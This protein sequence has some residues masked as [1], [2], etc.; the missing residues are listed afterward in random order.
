MMIPGW[1]F[2][3]AALESVRELRLGARPQLRSSL[4]RRRKAGLRRPWCANAFAHTLTSTFCEYIAKTDFYIF[5]YI[6][7]YV[8]VYT[9]IYI[10]IFVVGFLF[11]IFTSLFCISGEVTQVMIIPGW[12]FAVAAS[13]SV[14]EPRLGARPQSCGARRRRR[15]AGLRR[16]WCGN[17]FAHTLTSTFCEYIPKTHFYIFIYIYI[18]IYVYVYTYI[19]IYMYISSFWGLEYFFHCFVF[20]VRT[21]GL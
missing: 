14:R 4:R 8:Y 12:C 18:C 5:V 10:Y 7:I 20:Q 3:V 15:K 19:Y 17:A 21:P 9:Y 13:E 16:P 6:C 2:A 1:C 11:R